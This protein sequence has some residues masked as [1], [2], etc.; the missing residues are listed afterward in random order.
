[1]SDQIP[2]VAVLRDIWAANGA[3]EAEF[4]TCLPT[5]NKPCKATAELGIQGMN[6]PATAEVQRAEWRRQ[7]AE[8]GKV[9]LNAR[10]IGKEFA[11][12]IQA[13]PHA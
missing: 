3:N 13:A 1:M 7:M 11:D 9:P 10:S 6:D 2:A 4:D 5:N 8:E 12:K